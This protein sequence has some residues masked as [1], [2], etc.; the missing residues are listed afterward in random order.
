[1][2]AILSGFE[3]T[4]QVLLAGLSTFRPYH[5][6]PVPN[7]S[8]IL[9]HMARGRHAHQRLLPSLG[10]SRLVA[11]I[12]LSQYGPLPGASTVIKVGELSK[13]SV[14]VGEGLFAPPKLKVKMN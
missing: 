8:L 7:N 9:E 14:S 3:K 11:R 5:V 2:Q 12:Q 6:M 4:L 1:M 10:Q 13:I